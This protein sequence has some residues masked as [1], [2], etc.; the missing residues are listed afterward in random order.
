[1]LLVDARPPF[2]VNQGRK[3][4][5]L[6][7]PESAFTASEQVLKLAAEFD[8]DDFSSLRLAAYLYQ[9]SS[10]TVSNAATCVFNIHKVTAP[11]WVDA[12]VYSVAGSIT[13]NQYFFADVADTLIPSIDMA[14]GDTIMVEA[15][16][17]RLTETY[18]D[19]IYV[20]H[21]GIFDSHLRLKNKV[22]FLDLT[23][24]DE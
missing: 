3:W 20:N 23:K 8:Q 10:G 12:P 18:R 6:L 11:L 5:I 22:A 13:P 14:G 21:L 19:R 4:Q 9:P 16:V 24:L 7:G 1:M 15:V 2:Y 17:T